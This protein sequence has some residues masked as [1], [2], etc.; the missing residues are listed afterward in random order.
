LLSFRFVFEDGG[1]R[2][3]VHPAWSAARD[4]GVSSRDVNRMR[5]RRM[6]DAARPNRHALARR[7]ELF[8]AGW[9]PDSESRPASLRVLPAAM[10]DD[11][12]ASK[13]IA[14]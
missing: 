3:T 1:Q 10:F 12:G 14:S 6:A 8:V 13:D 9:P 2:R 4:H 7:I 11:G 5:E